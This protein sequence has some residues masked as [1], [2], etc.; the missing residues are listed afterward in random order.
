M[1]N[2]ACDATREF[3]IPD[4]SR[5]DR[6]AALAELMEDVFAAWHAP[7]FHYLMSLTGNIAEA[8][9]LTQE[10]FLRLCAE[11]QGGRRIEHLRPWCFR[12]AHNLAATGGRRKQT[13]D[14]YR[15][16]NAGEE[17]RRANYQAGIEETLLK[18]EQSQRVAAAMSKLTEMERQCL[19]LRTEGLLYRE[20]GEVL[21]IRV[22]TVQTLLARGM[23]K[24]VKAL[25]E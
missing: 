25:D 5:P 15:A 3:A 24:I 23:K 17:T 1:L 14:R 6:A 4:L 18:R 8:E 16:A 21:D 7:V 20:I 9:D 22:P 11:L 2:P 19:F 10:V 13:E 12:V